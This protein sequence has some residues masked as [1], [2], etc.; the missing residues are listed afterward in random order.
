MKNNTLKIIVVSL[1]FVFGV[2]QT[3]WGDDSPTAAPTC[4]TN[5]PREGSDW[6]NI[7]NSPCIYFNNMYANYTKVAIL[8]GRKWDF[9][10]ADPGSEGLNLT[11]IENTN[12]YYRKQDSW[13]HYTTFLFIQENGWGWESNNKVTDRK[14]SASNYTNTYNVGMN[15]GYHMFTA[16]CGEKGANLGYVSN[17][18]RDAM[19]QPRQNVKI[20]LST[21]GGSTYTESASYL[22]TIQASRYTMSSNNAVSS[23][24]KTLS[25]SSSYAMGVIS[26]SITFTA[27]ATNTGYEF[28]GWGISDA[29]P[30]QKTNTYNYLIGGEATIYAYYKK[31]T[32]VYT[33]RFHANWPGSDPMSDPPTQKVEKN[34]CAAKPKMEERKW[35][36]LEGWYTDE[37]CT[38]QWMFGEPVTRDMDLYAHWVGGNYP[39]MAILA[40]F[41]NDWNE[42]NVQKMTKSEDGKSASYTHTFTEAVADKEFGLRESKNDNPNEQ[43]D[44]WALETVEGPITAST[45]VQLYSENK[46]GKGNTKNIKI[47]VNE[48]Q[49]VTFT[50]DY[51]TKKLTV[52][53]ALDNQNKYRLVYV[54]TLGGTT[55][56]FHPS[57][58]IAAAEDAHMDTVSLYVKPYE[59]KASGSNTNS[60]YVVLQQMTDGKAWVEKERIDVKKQ[61]GIFTTNGVY[62][63]VLVQ[64]GSGASL[65]IE[66][67]HP[68]SG[69]YYIRLGLDKGLDRDYRSAE[70]QFRFSDYASKYDERFDHYFCQWREQGKDVRFC[71]ACDY[72]ACVSD[73]L[74]QEPAGDAHHNYTDPNGIMQHSANVRFMWNSEN[75]SIDRDYLA[76]AGENLH[77]LS[78]KGIKDMAKKEQTDL[79]LTDAEN[80]VYQQDVYACTGALVKLL[81]SPY[82]GAPKNEY[83]YFK[84][85]AGEGFTKENAVQLIGG[86]TGQTLKV[87]VIYDFKS[88]HLISAWLPND[89]KEISGE[90]PL[91][92]DLILIRKEHSDA[93]QITFSD[94]KASITKVSQA[95]GVVS[96]SRR[97]FADK[98]V[99]ANA[100]KFYWISFPFDVHLSEVFSSLTYGSQYLIKYYDGAERAAKGNWIDSP[101]FWKMYTKR[102]GVVLKKGVGYLLHVNC[103]DTASFFAKGNQEVNI[104]FPSVNT[105]SMTISGAIEKT[106]VPAHP[107]NIERGNRKIYDSNWNLIGVPAWANVNAMGLPNATEMGDVKFLYEYVPLTNGYNA[108]T[109]K[110]Y[111]FGS[112]KAYMV[113]FAGT[114]NWKEKAITTAEK[115]MR[116]AAEGGAEDKTV[117]LELLRG[118]ERLDHTFVQ[119][120]DNEG[121]TEGF[122]LNSDLTKVHN[123]GCNLYT[124]I[125]SEQ[126]EAAANI[127]PMSERTIY[128]PVGVS[129]DSDGTYTFALPEEME[130]MDVRIADAETGYTHNLL[131]SPYEV[132][133]TAGSHTQRFSLEIHA[134]SQVTTGCSETDAAGERLRKV[135]LNGQLLLQTGERLYDAQGK[136]LW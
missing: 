87:R 86:T 71:V 109:A 6:H 35:Y 66:K 52:S 32:P 38:E 95:Y 37:A 58:T 10:G 45:T 104:Y 110:T 128:V 91:H 96:L 20:M 75:N 93:Q 125:G 40:S 126:I 120:S 60:C 94:E 115:Q 34:M 55:H 30:T 41:L 74:V 1:I 101:S 119:L 31:N 81:V 43:A 15:G 62:N 127:L 3:A 44:W 47:T 124:L 59:R 53:Y 36:E 9:G 11:K 79:V 67:V 135:L 123:Q 57:H 122:D 50:F 80:W 18:N 26:S 2:L 132:S 88:N 22:G 92:S 51:V 17:S 64:D 133:L 134:S 99:P 5:E 65:P 21:D 78:A 77:L 13:A 76:G 83:L 29:G 19:L 39:T 113:Q 98:D 130:G 103:N 61:T 23:S 73:T 116:A 107:C 129:V 102:D 8:L 49:E 118:E 27:S 12:L 56:V 72:S 16:C 63:F 68:Y 28:V 24:N 42:N 7:S 70:K 100:K 117:C 114:I 105:D 4:S 33:V 112:M 90:L 54:E 108:V 111:N 46:I 106:I 131:F 121:I 85:A 84:G 82:N 48:P 14:N 69:N 89:S 136:R 97:H 25:E